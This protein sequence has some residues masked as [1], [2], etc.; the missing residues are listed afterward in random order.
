MPDEKVY[1]PEPITPV[2]T[3][4]DQALSL[5]ERSIEQ[6]AIIVAIGAFTNLALLE[7][8]SPG[9]LSPGERKYSY[10]V[11]DGDGFA[12]EELVTTDPLPDGVA[13]RRPLQVRLLDAG[14]PSWSATAAES[15][16]HCL[17]ARA[18]LRPE[19]RSLSDGSPAL[20]ATPSHYSPSDRSQ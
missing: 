6:G 19:A 14:S 8:R 16:A 17:A 12:S 1:W 4:L 7:K 18:E 20:D 5:L 2:E 10:R 3:S 11:I 13:G 9:K 15:R